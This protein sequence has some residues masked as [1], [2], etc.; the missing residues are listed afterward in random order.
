MR[1]Y[2]EARELRAAVKLAPDNAEAHTG[3]G[4]TQAVLD[5]PADARRHANRALLHGG[6]SYLILHNVACIFAVLS[7]KGGAKKEFQDLALDQLD[8]AVEL[9]LKGGGGEPRE[10][11]LMISE[12]AFS[13]E[14][15]ARPEFQALLEKGKKK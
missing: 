4:F 3:L 5:L 8:R 2:K 6:G 1:R 9:W 12:D 13:P 10:V 7:D 14:L 11:N 15:K